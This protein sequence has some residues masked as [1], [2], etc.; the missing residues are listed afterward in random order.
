MLPIASLGD[1]LQFYCSSSNEKVPETLTPGH[2]AHLSQSEEVRA[3]TIKEKITER[4]K[5]G[6]YV[7]SQT[8]SIFMD[9]F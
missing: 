1:H 9:I 4:S 6:N 7:L 8:N 5:F 2:V 3:G